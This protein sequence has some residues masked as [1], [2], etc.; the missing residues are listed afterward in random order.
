MFWRPIC[1][2]EVYP[3]LDGTFM[4]ALEKGFGCLKEL[5]MA[6]I[7]L[8]E[9]FITI[10]ELYGLKLIETPPGADDLI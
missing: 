3:I 7:L 4:V 9:A 6:V 2:P 10:E 8:L 1:T 5:V